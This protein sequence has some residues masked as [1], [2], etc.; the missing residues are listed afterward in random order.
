MLQALLG[1][2]EQGL[3]VGTPRIPKIGCRHTSVS[4]Q[5]IGWYNRTCEA[6]RVNPAPPG[7]SEPSSQSSSPR[8]TSPETVTELLGR[9]GRGDRDAANQ[10][11]PLVYE[12]LH[13]LAAHYMRNERPGHT[14]QATALVNEAY[15]KL[16]APQ[17]NTFHSRSHFVAVAAQAMR[18]LLIDH[19][20]RR[21][22]AKH[23]GLEQKIALEDNIVG[24]DSQSEEL[25]S[26]DR[27][28]DRLAKIDARQAQVVELRYF[29]GLSVDE[30]ARV[31]DI[32]PKTVKRD[33]S[34][35]R[36]WLKREIEG[37]SNL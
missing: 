33:W 31:L 12:E 20:R 14:L 25:L 8:T 18:H 11:M 21:R 2:P 7:Q 13:R 26:V 27:A 5:T 15:L 24:T 4:H 9:I 34:V 16:I 28:L 6:D 22:T 36:A 3:Y 32:S 37:K 17:Q 30:T 23:G 35:A 10:L 1:S 19:A 29:G